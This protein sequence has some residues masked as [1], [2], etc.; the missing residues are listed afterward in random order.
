MGGGGWSEA[1]LARM[2]DVLYSHVVRGEVPGLVALVSRRGE[3][4]VEALGAQAV[5]GPPVRRDT[6]FRIASMTKPVVAVAALILVEECRLRLDEPVDRL[7]PELAGRRVLRRI[8]GPLDDTVPAQRPITLRDLLTFRMGFGQ[9]MAPPDAYPILRAAHELQ[10]GMGP[11][12]PAATPAPDEWLRRLGTLPLMHQPGEEWHY[13]TGS[14]VLSVLI[15]RAAGQ[16]LEDFLRERIFGPLGMEDTGFSVPDEKR[17]RFATSYVADPAT[18]GLRVFDEAASGQWSRPPAFPSGGGGLVS[19][20]DDFLAFARMLLDNGR[21]GGERLLSRRSV[22]AMVTDQL[23]AAQRAGASP[24]L[25]EQRG[26]G[27]GVA[28]V[29][30]RS[31]ATTAPGQYGWSGGL[32]TTWSND[33]GEGL[34]AIL[35]TQRA[36]DAAGPPAVTLDFLTGAF[37][38][39]D[40]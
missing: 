6:I 14:D 8:D 20:A 34:I 5:D 37:A 16:P 15:A 29:N 18:G 19:T 4:R 22:E 10:I 32:G 27:F 40:D 1:R 33:P 31:D 7:L 12:S 35:L 13:N 36:W 3:V 26:W 21:H 25:D 28:V 38:A 17:D 23:T 9:L 30:A 39:I 2:R 24:F 11:P